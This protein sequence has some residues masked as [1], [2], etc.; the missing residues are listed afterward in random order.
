MREQ[1]RCG[2]DSNGT[3]CGFPL[4]G[5]SAALRIGFNGGGTSAGDF[6]PDEYAL[7]ALGDLAA[8][9][10]LGLAGTWRHNRRLS[11]LR[12]VLP[13]PGTLNGWRH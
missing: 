9:D 13:G 6:Q 5:K 11:H 8:V 1:T 4:I 10:S 7:V 12:Q 3:V 2:F